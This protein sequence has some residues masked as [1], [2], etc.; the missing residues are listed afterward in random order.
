MAM[1]KGKTP[2]FPRRSYFLLL[3][4]PGSEIRDGKTLGS[5][6]NIPNPQHSGS[7]SLRNRLQRIFQIIIWTTSLHVNLPY[8]RSIVGTVPSYMYNKFCNFPTFHPKVIQNSESQIKYLNKYF[9]V[10]VPSKLE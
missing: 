2:F 6:I 9:F 8:K 1:K 7:F 10:H 4:D 5:E 3:L